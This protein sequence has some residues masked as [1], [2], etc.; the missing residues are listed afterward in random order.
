MVRGWANILAAILILSVFGLTLSGIVHDSFWLDEG[1]TAATIRDEPRAIDSWRDA[2]RYIR[3]S[4]L[5]TFERVRADVHPPLYFMLL[6]S[7]SLLVGESQFVLRLPSAFMGTLALAG[8]YAVA[9][10]WFNWRTGLIAVL[11]LGTSGFFIYYSREAR[12][13]TLYLALTTIATAA[14][15][16]W[17]HK[18]TLWRG[19]FYGLLMALALYTHYVGAL[20]FVA[21][22][23]HLLITWRKMDMNN[24]VPTDSPSL[25][26]GRG[27]GGG[28]IPYLTALLLFFAW[29]PFAYA[30]WQA[31][32]HGA[33]GHFIPTN[34]H[35]VSGVILVLTCGYAV[36]YVLPFLLSRL[37]L[38]TITDR[39][40]LQAVLL[41]L[42][43]LLL[44]ITLLLL[45]NARGYGIFQM[46]YI[47]ATVPA[48]VLLL[49]VAIDR[50]RSFAPSDTMIRRV[51]DSPSLPAGRGLGGGV[52]AVKLFFIVLITYTQLATYDTYFPAKPRWREAV[53]QAAAT[54]TALEP[55]II[56]IDPYSPIAYYDRFYPVADGIAIDIGWRWFTAAEIRTTAAYLDNNESV[57]AILPMQA[58]QSWDA[59]AALVDGR[60]VGYRDSVQGTLFY[61]FDAESDDALAFQ[62]GTGESAVPV[63]WDYRSYHVGDTICPDDFLPN[64]S[65]TVE[66]SLV[67]NYNETVIAATDDCLAVPDETGILHVRLS[68]ID[69]NGQR[70]PLVEHGNYWGEFLVLGAVSI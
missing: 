67:R 55:A 35:T 59:V 22:G 61:R 5:H 63:A 30:Q 40:M 57:W 1:W 36:N 48:W 38:D 56:H 49:A 26:V 54:R 10:Q 11:L 58:P 17:W 21:H 68:L 34:W 42:L 32:P 60:G 20:I 28:V 46:R 39:K 19:L 25:R 70:L 44:P 51:I 3:D 53:I 52:A 64:Q 69:N 47:I 9:K 37:V 29:I 2:V 15:S 45:I 41:L 18:P 65:H 6:D 4:L 13:Y 62:F 50:I 14:Y 33:A 7:W 16:R 12:M 43:W 31:H 24:H 66:I 8:I 27:L 23:I